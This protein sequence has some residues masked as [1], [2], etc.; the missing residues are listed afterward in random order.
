MAL[1][2]TT[3]ASQFTLANS[4]KPNN[5]GAGYILFLAS[6]D[7][8][9]QYVTST[10]GLI[11]LDFT[12][13]VDDTTLHFLTSNIPV[14]TTADRGLMSTGDKSLLDGISTGTIPVST[15]YVQSI[16][17]LFETPSI[18]VSSNLSLTKS[19]DLGTLAISETTNIALSSDSTNFLK[20]SDTTDFLK[21]SDTTDFLEIPVSSN[22]ETFLTRYS[23]ISTKV[24]D[25]TT[26]G[27][28]G[29]L[30]FQTT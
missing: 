11:D 25:N 5:P 18:E 8:V 16:N 14:A 13:H 26:D 9:P 28:D 21:S 17:G 27:A 22:Y 29:Y 3:P 2:T 23:V 12:A 4:S 30:W 1:W 20:S 15:D 24:P 6:S 7:G 10:G 19:S